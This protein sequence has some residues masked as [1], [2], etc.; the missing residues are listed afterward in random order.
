MHRRAVGVDDIRLTAGQR[1]VL[2]KELEAVGQRQ[3]HAD[4][5]RR[6]DVRNRDLP[7][8]LPLVGA[9]DLCRLEHILRH[10]LKSC[11][12]N[13]HHI[14]DLLPAH[15]DD[16]APEAELCIE[17]NRCAVMAQ[18]AVKNHAPDIAQ[19]DAA[20]QVRHEKDGPE[21][22]G[23]LDALRQRIRNREGKDIDDDQRHDGKHRRIAERIQEA[24]VVE[25][26]DIVAQANPRPLAGCLELAEGQKQS[27]QKRI[28]E[29]DAERSR[30]RKQ[31]QPEHPLN[32]SSNQAAVDRCWISSTLQYSYPHF[33]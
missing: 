25:R 17:Q 9:V 33:R 14:A 29:P 23:S 3:E 20:N 22:V 5:N 7:Q 12:V 28:H 15:E 13:D 6:H 21:H 26:L 31:K 32:R 1:E 19:H 18:N 10:R 11:N 16:Q 2:V 4:R 27:L 24:F 30:H 8:R